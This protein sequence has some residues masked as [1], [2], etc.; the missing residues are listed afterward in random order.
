MSAGSPS[1]G[2]VTNS[3]FMPPLVPGCQRSPSAAARHSSPSRGA[4]GSS[5]ARVRRPHGVVVHQRGE[6]A[7]HLAEPLLG[8]D[9]EEADLE[10]APARPHRREQRGQVLVG[11]GERRGAPRERGVG[12]HR[13]V[14]AQQPV[15][16]RRAVG[17][18]R[19][20]GREP[21]A[22]ADRACVRRGQVRSGQVEHPPLLE[23]G[24]ARPPVEAD[25]GRGGAAH[26]PAAGRADRVEV[27][28]HRG[29]P[30]GGQLQRHLVRRAAVDGGGVEDDAGPREVGAQRRQ[31]APQPAD[32]GR[33][34]PHG[35]FSS[36]CPPGSNATADRGGR[37]NPLDRDRHPRSRSRG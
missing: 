2:S 25:L 13:V 12:G 29:V 18:D 37:A 8:L 14:A 3:V 10:V 1:S 15:V 19:E 35:W 9:V 23:P 30:G 20:P 36:T 11:A 34:G 7:D 16:E 33:R 24:P 5:A 21:G 31:G 6:G 4:S 26:H 27:R 28:L 17:V 32:D 22:R